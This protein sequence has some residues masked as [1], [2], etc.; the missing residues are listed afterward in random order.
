[1]SDL[2][3]ITVSDAGGWI[4]YGPPA[5]RRRIGFHDYGA[6]YAVPGLYERVFYDE[7]RMH[8]LEVVVGLYGEALA[9]AGLDPAAQRVLDL[10]AGNGIAGAALRDAGARFVVGLDLEPA[11]RD[12]AA[13]DRPG[14][15]D[16]Y[17]VGDLAAWPPERLDDL[18][19]RSL[20]AMVAVAALGAGHVPPEVVRRAIGVL[21]P[22][23]VFAFAVLSELLPGSEDPAGRAT[24]YPDFIEAL[25]SGGGAEQLARREYVHRHTA[26]G[27]PQ[28]AVAF[29]GRRPQ[30]G[31]A[32]P[33]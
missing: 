25:F 32:Q 6:I 23:G 15:Y 29:A 5:R 12:A 22:G 11:A 8:T 27:S 21:E 26:D 4:E 9:G 14:V 3:A 20:T 31:R 24:G 16:D 18:R 10:G 28:R 13:R 2:G 33:V 17:L 1:M 7:L 19:A 30:R